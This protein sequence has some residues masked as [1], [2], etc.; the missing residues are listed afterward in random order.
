MFTQ[1]SYTASALHPER[2]NIVIVP[3]VNGHDRHLFAANDK[4]QDRV[5]SGA[6]QLATR[7]RMRNQ[8]QV[9]RLSIPLSTPRTTRCQWE[10]GRSAMT[11]VGPPRDA[12][13]LPKHEAR[14]AYSG[15]IVIETIPHP[16]YAARV[17]HHTS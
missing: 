12:N 6:A 5:S 4:Q 16:R 15:L 13:H 10:Q 14:I 1:S 9:D 11:E 8:D 2:Q 7:E 3:H 17:L